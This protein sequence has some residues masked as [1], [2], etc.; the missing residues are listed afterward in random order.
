MTKNTPKFDERIIFFIQCIVS[1]SKTHLSDC[2]LWLISMFD[3]PSVSLSLCIFSFIFLH[4]TLWKWI[5]DARRNTKKKKRQSLQSSNIDNVFLLFLFPFHPLRFISLPFFISTNIVAIVGVYLYS[6]SIATCLDSLKKSF[7]LLPLLR[8]CTQHTVR[9]IASNGMHND[10]RQQHLWHNAMH[11]I[12]YMQRWCVLAFVCVCVCCFYRQIEK[13]IFV[14][15]SWK[16]FPCPFDKANKKNRLLWS[17]P[18]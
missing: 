11:C 15:T 5:H 16:K 2:M 4:S 1:G 17:A 14:Q 13:S 9:W 8:T 3:Y 12:A 18:R 10:Y 6:A 7:S